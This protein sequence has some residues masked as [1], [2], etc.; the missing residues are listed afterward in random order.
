MISRIRCWPS[1][2]SPSAACRR[3]ALSAHEQRGANVGRG[4][5]RVSIMPS[6]FGARTP[7]C[8]CWTSPTCA[9]RTTASRF[10]RPGFAGARRSRLRRRPTSPMAWCLSP[11]PQA[12][13]RPPPFTRAV[14]I[15]TGIGDHHHRRPGGVRTAW[16][17][18]D[19]R[20]RAQ[21]P[22]PLPWACGSS[23]GM[24]RTRILVGEIRD[25]ET[26]G[27]AVQSALTGHLVFTTVHANSLFD[28]IGRSALWHRHVWL[29]LCAQRRGGAAPAAPAVQPAGA[30]PC[31]GS[32]ARMVLSA[33]PAGTTHCPPPMAAP[34]PRLRATGDVLWWPRCTC[35]PTPSATLSCGKPRSR[36]SNNSPLPTAE[37]AP[38]VPLLLHAR[39]KHVAHGETTLPEEIYRVVGQAPSGRR[40]AIGCPE[41]CVARVVGGTGS[42][43][44]GVW[45]LSLWTP[46]WINWPPG[47]PSPGPA[48]DA[49]AGWSA[50]P[51]DD[52][53]SSAGCS[54][55]LRPRRPRAWH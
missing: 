48:P 53:A 26:A 5:L 9:P 51:F 31:G 24:T 52:R 37:T 25:A 38:Q 40:P 36:N 17:A 47:S 22:D 27:I 41:H 29:C 33:S 50:L 10:R 28:V 18:A 55:W 30:R 16:R 34:V 44:L 32:R 8:A 11:A 35:C 20:Q 54:P 4:G 6:V 1:S 13:A 23:C 3:T 43:E 42:G 7:C 21:G 45:P 14:E 39:C 2:T 15:N 49:L 46:G 12:A 19:P